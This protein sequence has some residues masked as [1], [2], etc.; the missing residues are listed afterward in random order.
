MLYAIANTLPTGEMGPN[1]VFLKYD[2]A[3]NLL[4][5]A[6]STGTTLGG[7]VAPGTDRRSSTTR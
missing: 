4:Y 5:L 1:G 7:G 6:D 2:Q 3:L